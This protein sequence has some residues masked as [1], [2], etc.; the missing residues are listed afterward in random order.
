[1][2]L[3]CTT[4]R[5]PARGR[6]RREEGRRE[7]VGGYTSVFG[8]R[9]DLRGYRTPRPLSCTTYHTHSVLTEHFLQTSP[10][11]RAK[12]SSAGRLLP[13]LQKRGFFRGGKII[14]IQLIKFLS[15]NHDRDP[16]QQNYL[17]P[18]YKGSKSKP[19]MGIETA[20]LFEPIL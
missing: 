8:V 4:V 5:H 1:M 6:G 3:F 10:I 11:G 20:K 16:G 17:N 2:K 18:F 15:Q 19:W 13:N 9:D 7:S 12:R 14:W